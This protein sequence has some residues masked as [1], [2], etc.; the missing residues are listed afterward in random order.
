[1]AAPT[2]ELD[3]SILSR[4][5]TLLDDSNPETADPKNRQEFEGEV[6][7]PEP[8]R[9]P[10]HEDPEDEKP[11]LAADGEEE[12]EEIAAKADPEG[13]GEGEEAAEEEGV[14]TLSDLARMFEVEE[15][16]LLNQLQFD[17]GDGNKIPLSQIIDGYKKAPQAAKQLEELSA[18]KQRFSQEVAQLR[19]QTDEKIRDL[20]ASAQALLDVTN[21]EFAGI[22]WNR[23]QAE[24][25]SQYL[26]LK[27]RQ[28]ERGQLIQ[29]A[30]EKMRKIEQERA[31]TD[32]EHAKTTR[33][34]EIA[35]LHEIRPEW[36]KPEVAQAAMSETNQYL[37]GV[38]WTQEEINT[39]QD[40]RQLLVAYDA[41]QY[42]KLQNQAPQKLEK[43]RSL[44]KP[45]A[46]LRSTARRDSSS[47]AQRQ[48]QKN[49]DRLRQSGDERDA[50]RLFEELL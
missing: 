22:E 47:D 13:E 32:L 27:E 17:S 2:G 19:T 46:V 41:A 18:E 6:K 49:M 42:R 8:E 48:A 25:P 45:K 24:D 9:K 11:P 44:P 12:E 20:A 29:S 26:M 38:G 10:A 3:S 5:E 43:L 23:L 4:L 30:I 50:A 14:Q 35:R 31:T 39:I 21:E 28:R 7:E 1:M 40:H 16:E 33:S 37:L 36:T 34:Q 15:T